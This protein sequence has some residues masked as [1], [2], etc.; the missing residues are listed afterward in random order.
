ML[1]AFEHFQS[2]TFLEDDGSGSGVFC[3]LF[4][5]VI[6]RSHFGK[7]YVNFGDDTLSDRCRPDGDT[8]A[9]PL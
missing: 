5:S 9:A 1:P 3:G 7:L 8:S 4:F 2:A 6:Y